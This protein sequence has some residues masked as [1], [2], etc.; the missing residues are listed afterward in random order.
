LGIILLPCI[1]LN[2]YFALLFNDSLSTARTYN[3]KQNYGTNMYGEM[4][5][6]NKAITTVFKLI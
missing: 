6:Q 4:S 2:G 1:E 5:I 3:V